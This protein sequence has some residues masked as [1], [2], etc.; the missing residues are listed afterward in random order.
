MSR[1]SAHPEFCRG[2]QG[3]LTQKKQPPPRTLQL[4]HA[5]GL[6]GV[7]GGWVFSYGRGAP[8]ALTPNAVEQMGLTPST[9]VP[10]S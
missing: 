8:V 9:G 7:L 2:V 5:W 1:N 3:Y 6:M 10:R 4:A